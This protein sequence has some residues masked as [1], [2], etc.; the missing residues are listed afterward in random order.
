MRLAQCPG[1]YFLSIRTLP[2]VE[3]IDKCPDN[4]PPKISFGMIVFNGEPF[5]RYNLQALYPFAHQ[6]IVVEGAAPTAKPFATA[7]GHS[8][9]GTL[10]TLKW[11]KQDCDPENKLVLVT[12]EDEGHPDGTWTEKDEMSQAYARRATGNYLWQVDVDEF[13]RPEDMRAIV[14]MLAADRGITAVTFRTLAFWGGID[15]VTDGIFL[16][17]AAQNFHRLFAWGPGF[18]YVTHR[19]P[20]VTDAGGRD[21]REIRHMTGDD[22]ARKGIFMYHYSFI[23]PFQVRFKQ[24]YYGGLSPEMRR[25]WEVWI[26]NYFELTRPLMIDDTSLL[27]GPSWLKRFRGRHP[28]AILALW[29]DVDNGKVRVE[30]RPTDDIDRLLGRRWYRAL[31]TILAVFWRQVDMLL[32]LKNKIA[33]GLSL[34]VQ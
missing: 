9:D 18:E 24:A 28:D 31:T 30:K 2:E 21:L 32:A 3:Y 13:Y 8:S 5:V 25:K 26:R 19:P 16:R 15:Y 7:Q 20:T 1:Q 11:F 22:M 6:I 12:A 27:Y 10:E 17:K 14:A 23:F 33:K 4:C 34:A 29:R